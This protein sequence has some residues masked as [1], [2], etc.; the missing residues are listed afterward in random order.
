MV[1]PQAPS[2]AHGSLLP[3]GAVALQVQD[4]VWAQGGRGEQEA[5][6]RFDDVDEFG[7]LQCRWPWTTGV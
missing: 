3:H 4:L 1:Q 5:V 2:R 6:V 7:G